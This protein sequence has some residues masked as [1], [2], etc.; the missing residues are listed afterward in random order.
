VKLLKKL[1]KFGAIT[2]F[3]FKKSEKEFDKLIFDNTEFVK[4]KIWQS[5]KI[6]KPFIFCIEEHV[7]LQIS[8]TKNN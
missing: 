4:C 7:C 2:F 8:L 1:A 3:I 6:E 5:Q